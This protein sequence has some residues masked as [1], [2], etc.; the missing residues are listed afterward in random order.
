[1]ITPRFATAAADS[2]AGCIQLL[3]LMVQRTNTH[4]FDGALQIKLQHPSL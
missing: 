4:T 3:K 1:M 2:D